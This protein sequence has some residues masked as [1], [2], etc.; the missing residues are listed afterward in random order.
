[1]PSPS[2]MPILAGLGLPIIGYGLIY[3]Y[4][5]SIVGGLIL[6]SGLY[7]WAFEPGTE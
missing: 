1:M 4:Y 6:L 5:I 7:G 2:Y 3:G